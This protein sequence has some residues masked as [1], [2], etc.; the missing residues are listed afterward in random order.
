MRRGWERMKASNAAHEQGGR[1]TTKRRGPICFVFLDGVGL[2]PADSSNPLARATMPNLHALLGG[3]MVAGQLVAR[4]GV[5]LWPLDA[6]L[7]VEGLP[8]SATGQTALFTGVNAAALVGAHLAAY[9]TAPLR[10]VIARYSLLK[11]AT[12]QGLRATF[13]NAYTNIYW[14]RVARRELRHSVSTLATMAAGLRFRTLDDLARGEAVYWDITHQVMRSHLGLD[15]PLLPP[16]EAGQRLARLTAAHDLVLFESFLTDLAGHGRLPW[17]AEDVLTLMDR[18]LGGLLAALPEEA[19]LVLSSDHGNLEDT[20]TQA[21]TRN[22]VP[23]LVVGPGAVA[24]RQARAIT[25][26]TPGILQWLGI[27]NNED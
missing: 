18:F 11:Q 2:A 9:P 27:R 21:H 26:V 7:G 17:P 3:P 1:A 8:Q 10:E 15:V 13:A 24:F 5:L 14:Q 4:D 22:P 19:T 12:D 25:D 23:L 20:S 6:C 16:E